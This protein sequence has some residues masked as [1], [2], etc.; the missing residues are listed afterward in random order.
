MQYYN[1]AIII[2]EETLDIIKQLPNVPGSVSSAEG[3]R[4]Y[5]WEGTYL[6]ASCEEATADLAIG[7]MMIM[8]QRAPYTDPL[9]ILIC[10][11]STPAPNA[12][13]D[14]C[15]SIQPEAADPQWVIERMVSPLVTLPE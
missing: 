10:G 11:G 8:P 14:N 5:P 2:D 7:S 12:G 1:E 15:V 3:G 13:I 9:E 6:M 4:N